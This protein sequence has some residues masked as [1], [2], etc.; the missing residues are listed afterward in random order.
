MAVVAAARSR[1]EP[2]PAAPAG[3]RPFLT[4]T[5]RDFLMLSY[6]IE[7][8]VLA[9][10][11]PRGTELDLWRGRA[12]VSLVGFRFCEARLHGVRVPWHQNFAEV[13]LRFYVRRRVEGGWRRGVVFVRELCPKRAVVAVAR[14]IYGERFRRVPLACHTERDV[15]STFSRDAVAER[16]RATGVPPLSSGYS[17]GTSHW[18]D[19]SGTPISRAAKRADE[20]EPPRRIAFT[21]RDRGGDLRLAGEV[22]ETAASPP[23]AESLAEFVV[24][25]YWAYTAAARRST[26]EYLVT[27]T[28]WQIAEADAEFA[29][30]AWRQYGP[31][32]APFLNAPPVAAF[33]ATG[34]AV[35]VYRGI[36]L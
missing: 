9:A 36:R 28:P 22:L 29:G 25:H 3:A 7:P 4:A 14:W 6:E 13:N 18:R 2:V 35:Q 17:L 34:S 32:F 20:C 11:V 21:W 8:R 1:I 23:A 30:N 12:F 15:E 27:H 10:L 16:A 19:A 24:E 33:W 26:R 5:W 31:R